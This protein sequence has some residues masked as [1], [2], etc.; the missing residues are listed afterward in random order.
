MLNKAMITTYYLLY[1][2]YSS[3][4]ENK[5]NMHICISASQYIKHMFYVPLMNE[6]RNKLSHS[7]AMGSGTPNSNALMY[8][9]VL[10]ACKQ[11]KNLSL[12]ACLLTCLPA[13]IA[14]FMP[15]V[16]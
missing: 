13:Y 7:T 3:E 1:S 11:D 9:L 10:T 12:L 14:T 5:A 15:V 2:Y 4:Q 8:L 16:T 6:K